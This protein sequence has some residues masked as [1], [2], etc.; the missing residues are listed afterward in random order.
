MVVGAA[1]ASERQVRYAA[2]QGTFMTISSNRVL[3]AV[4]AVS[5]SFMAGC[6][7][8]DGAIAKAG[9]RDVS[10]RGGVVVAKVGQRD[11]SARS[12]TANMVYVRSADDAATFEIDAFK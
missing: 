7:A 1:A 9:Q 11:I 8:G 10:A 3:P 12:E 6:A 5:I 2:S 4:L